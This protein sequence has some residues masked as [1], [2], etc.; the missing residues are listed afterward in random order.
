VNAPAPVNRMRALRGL[1]AGVVALC[2][3]GTVSNEVPKL[4]LL[5]AMVLAGGGPDAYESLT[6]IGVLAGPSANFELAKLVKDVGAAA[7]KTF[8]V[9]LDFFVAD[10]LRILK[11]DGVSLLATPEPDPKDGRA[12]IVALYGAGVDPATGTYAID[13][14]LDRLVSPRVREQIVRAIAAK[15]GAAD[16]ARFRTVFA[17][18]ITRLYARR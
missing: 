12:L 13:G 7:V 14:M 6:L 10:A 9:R 18:L 3:S 1:G 15:H 4:R 17:L 2:I 11:R 16:V 5:L 8:I